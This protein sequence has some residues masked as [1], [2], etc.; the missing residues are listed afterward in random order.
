VH[1]PLLETHPE[2]ERARDWFGSGSWMMSFELRDTARLVDVVNRLRLPLKATGLADTRTL[3]IPV[4]P[5]IFWEMGAEARA[6]M[7]IAEGLVRLSVGLEA[8][9]DLIA[10]FDQALA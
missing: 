6:A 9:E 4:A 8:A 5:T 2:Y 3:I 1:Y 7:G 10:D